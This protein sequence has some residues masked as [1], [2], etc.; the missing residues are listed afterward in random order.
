MNDIPRIA[1]VRYC[2]SE[3][4]GE[5]LLCPK[6]MHSNTKGEDVAKAFTDHFEESGVDIKNVRHYN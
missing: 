6:P 5:E 2:D 4:V 3:Q 1:V